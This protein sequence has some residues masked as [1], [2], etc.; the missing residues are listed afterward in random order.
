M[1]KNMME[2][3]SLK[4]TGPLWSKISFPINLSAYGY[5]VPGVWRHEGSG[6]VVFSSAF[7]EKPGEIIYH[8]IIAPAIYFDSVSK[9]C[10]GMVSYED[11]IW[12]IN[13]FC[14][15]DATAKNPSIHDRVRHFYK[16]VKMP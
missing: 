3:E 5:P 14:A 15:H 11:A 16:S 1:E 4:P 9:P 12:A 6:I 2:I 8:I 7:S 13:Q 10:E